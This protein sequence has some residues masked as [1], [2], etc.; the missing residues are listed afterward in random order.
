MGE[1]ERQTDR[2]LDAWMRLRQIVQAANFNRFHRAGLSA[3]QFMALNV[4]PADGLTLSELARRLNLSAATLHK[5]VSSLEE[6]GLLVRIRHPGDAR[7]VNIRATPEGETMQ[8]TASQDFHRSIAA[9]FAALSRRRRDGLL[10]GLEELVAVGEQVSG[11]ARGEAATRR[12]GGAP[13]ARRK[14]ARSRRG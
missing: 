11:T 8:N 3:T 6:R 2:F 12:A 1:L 7:K 14:T 4:V 10:A 9:M 5:T 13:P